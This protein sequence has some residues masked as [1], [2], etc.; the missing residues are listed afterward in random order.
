MRR[1]ADYI[2]KAP[3]L[4]EIPEQIAQLEA[5]LGEAYTGGSQSELA[6]AE[7]TYRT[8]RESVA[9]LQ[10]RLEGLNRIVRI[11]G[12]VFVE[13]RS[14]QLRGLEGR[15]AEHARSLLVYTA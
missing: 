11:P 9:N 14:D 5:E 15:D 10:S 2:R 6:N 1:R 4:R 12:T 13:K 7:R 8:A 3:Q